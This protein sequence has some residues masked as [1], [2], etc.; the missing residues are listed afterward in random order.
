MPGCKIHVT[1]VPHLKIATDRAIPVALVVNE[2][3]TN[4]AKYAYPNAKCEVWVEVTEPERDS[5]AVSVRDEGIGLPANFN[6]EAGKRLGMRLV[7]ALT[8]QVEAELTV[9]RR[10][11]GTEFFFKLPRHRALADHV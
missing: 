10:T 7:T 3:I 2:L 5:I 1:T 8:A 11:P 9:R 4:S 6:L